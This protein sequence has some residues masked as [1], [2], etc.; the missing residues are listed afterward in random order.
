MSEFEQLKQSDKRN[1]ALFIVTAVVDSGSAVSTALTHSIK[2]TTQLSH[3]Q[4]Q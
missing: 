3:C 2:S 1:I 4:L